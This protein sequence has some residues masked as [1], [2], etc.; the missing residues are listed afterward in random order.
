MASDKLV[1]YMDLQY[2]LQMLQ[3]KSLTLL[4]PSSWDDKNDAHYVECYRNKKN[5]T[6][7]L[8]LCMTEASQTYHHWRIF[9][10]GSSGV[11]VY[12]KRDEFLDWLKEN[13]SIIGRNVIYRTVNQL[14]DDIVKEKIKVDDIPFIKRKAYKHEAEFRLVFDSPNSSKKIES[15]IFPLATIE[16]IVLNP[17]LPQSTVASIKQLIHSI[18]GCEELPVL[19]ATIIENKE[20]RL[21]AD[22]I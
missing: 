12:F 11:C 4:N 19:R 21:L 2:V 16:K 18:D 8:A 15:F 10:Q 13:E 3:S 6:S 14:K 7:V 5:L 17:W 1:R 20:W 9:T 22:G